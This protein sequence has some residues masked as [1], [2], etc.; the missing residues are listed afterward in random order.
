MASPVTCKCH[1]GWR[2]HMCVL[3]RKGRKE[4]TPSQFP[5]FLKHIKEDQKEFPGGTGG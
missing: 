2:D 1:Q 3:I 4:E 5:M